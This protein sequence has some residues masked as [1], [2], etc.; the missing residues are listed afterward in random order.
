MPEKHS[1]PGPD[2]ARAL[3]SV[4]LGLVLSAVMIGGLELY[5][6]VVG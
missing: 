2:W 6:R 4:V 3:A 5:V 1:D